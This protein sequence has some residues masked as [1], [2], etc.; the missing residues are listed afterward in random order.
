MLA[1]SCNLRCQQAVVSPALQ[2]EK[3]KENDEVEM[4]GTQTVFFRQGED[5]PVSAMIPHR[6]KPRQALSLSELSGRQ[7][8]HGH[9]IFS[10][11]TIA[12]SKSSGLCPLW[13]EWSWQQNQALTT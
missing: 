9:G 1:G 13:N 7:E 12:P 10:M 11:A 3:L 8:K 2:E 5:L 4:P 6:G